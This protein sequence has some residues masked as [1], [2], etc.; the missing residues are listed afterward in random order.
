MSGDAADS[1]SIAREPCL[2]T[3]PIL[4]CQRVTAIVCRQIVAHE[5]PIFKGNPYPTHLVFSVPCFFLRRP[6]GSGHRRSTTATTPTTTSTTRTKDAVTTPSNLHLDHFTG[7][8]ANQ[9]VEQLR[10][11]CV[12]HAPRRFCRRTLWS[13]ILGEPTQAATNQS[14]KS[15]GKCAL[16]RSC[17]GALVHRCV[18]WYLSRA[19]PPHHVSA[20]PPS[21]FPS[22]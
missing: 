13:S 3:L 4:P 1:S 14:A 16:V 12:C 8:N 20:F 11:C 17:T 21:P 19:L 18:P 15:L 10:L 9:R 2:P 7:S 6:A 22:M 5:F